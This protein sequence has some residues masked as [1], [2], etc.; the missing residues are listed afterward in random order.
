MM[1]MRTSASRILHSWSLFSQHSQRLSSPGPHVL[2][3]EVRTR[4]LITRRRTATAPVQTEATNTTLVNTEQA[5]LKETIPLAKADTK[6][7]SSRTLSSS[8]S[9]PPQHRADPADQT[10][11]QIKPPQVTTAKEAPRPDD[12]VFSRKLQA[13]PFV[14]GATTTELTKSH[15]FFLY[16]AIF[17]KSASEI[18]KIPDN[19]MIPEVAFIGRSNV[20]KSSLIN[21][22]V[23]RKNLVKTSSKPGH[24]RLMNFFKIGEKLSL[25][26][27][28]GYGWKSRD[29][30]GSM[31]MDYLRTR[32]K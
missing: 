4:A 1:P 18:H 8:Q 13:F 15:K 29:E 5:T 25:V 23:N 31:I 7:L 27:M 26:D 10:S 30:W 3:R 28:P 24:T 20:G 2:V 17:V 14:P 6:N 21:G 9:T 16:P 22:L 11:K 19:T 12:E 32:S